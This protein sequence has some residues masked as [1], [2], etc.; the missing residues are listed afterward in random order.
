MRKSAH[1]YSNSVCLKFFDSIPSKSF[2]TYSKD[3]Q[4]SVL[5]SHC[6]SRPNFYWPDQSTIM[7]YAQFFFVA[8]GRQVTS[9]ASRVLKLRR[10]HIPVRKQQHKRLQH[11]KYET[12][13]NFI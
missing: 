3:K 9:F 4:N 1:V 12:A 11:D 7:V 2:L 10:S 6:W 13:P 8:V 5:K